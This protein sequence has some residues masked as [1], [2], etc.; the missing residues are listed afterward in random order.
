MSRVLTCDSCG[1]P[2]ERV[3]LKL[4]KTVNTGPRTT[5]HTKYTDSADIGECCV[6]KI[7][8]INWTKRSTNVK[9]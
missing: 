2:M 6:V 5:D 4:Y 7:N 8:G 3:V 9:G 1:K